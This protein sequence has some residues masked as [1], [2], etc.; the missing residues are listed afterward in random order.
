MPFGRL[1]VGGC[2]EVYE[3]DLERA[4]MAHGLPYIFVFF[5]F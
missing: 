2:D 4:Y 3:V 1:W 5:I